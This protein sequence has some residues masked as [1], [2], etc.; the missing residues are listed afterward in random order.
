MIA[1]AMDRARLSLLALVLAALP[2]ARAWSGEPGGDE[3][4]GN[5]SI[6]SVNRS[7]SLGYLEDRLYYIE[8]DNGTTGSG[9]LDY[10]RGKQKGGR[11]SGSYMTADSH[12]YIEVQ[13]SGSEGRVGYTGYL[14]TVP[15]TPVTGTS[16]ATT[17]EPLIKFGKGFDLGSR[18]MATP[19]LGVGWRYWLRELGVGTV[20]DY[21]E[22]YS[23][24]YGLAGG[25]IQFSPVD[26]LVLGVDGGIG[27][28]FHAQINVPDF[29]L[30]DAPLGSKPIVKAGADLDFRV[31]DFLHL[32]V[33]ADYMHVQFGQSP[34]FVYYPYEV[35]EPYSKTTVYDGVAGIRIPL[36]MEE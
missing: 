22:S 14:Q 17:Q 4:Y 5:P 21:N 10:E 24:F 3:D 34:V 23:F 27:R 9:Y 30:D 28:T 25:M 33:S 35:W 11:I 18:V 36:W 15:P 31:A 6:L 29:G 1:A 16:R 8:P 12:L 26:R 13:W 20:G 32:F 19:Y 7:L 2:Y